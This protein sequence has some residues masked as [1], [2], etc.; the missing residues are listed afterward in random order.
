MRE[1]SARR[2]VDSVR[3]GSSWP[4]IVETEDG[5]R[6]TKLRGA[7]QGTGAL[8]AEIIVGGLADALGLH[9]PARSLVRLPADIES[10][11]RHEELRDLLRASV[12]LNLGFEYLKGAT[13]LKEPDL[14]SE[15]E[16]SQIVW[17]D[18]LVMNP[19]RTARNPN[20]LCWRDTFWLI[21]HGAALGFQHRWSAVTE[22]SPR[23]NS[24]NDHH[25]LIARATRLAHW[26]PILA[27]K[28]TREVLD[29]TVAA[30][31]DDFLAPLAKDLP[32]RRAAYAAFL[33]KRLKAPRPW[34]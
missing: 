6:F 12:G 17:L 1:H 8:V 5:L 23:R 2:V 25:L 27:A 26:D 21:D 30:V 10:A 3:R 34:I 20:I 22:D 24:T 33:W 7:A 19:D 14:I 4:V 31:P 15:D 13:D 16:A 9:V 18:G 32:R 29:S 11:D 28:L